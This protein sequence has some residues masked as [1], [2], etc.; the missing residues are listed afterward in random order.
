VAPFR[1][2]V[3][4]DPY[5]SAA[6]MR[7]ALLVV[8]SDGYDWS[9]PAL[10]DELTYTDLSL[11]RTPTQL[12]VGMTQYSLLAAMRGD[13]TIAAD[14]PDVY[15][16]VCDRVTSYIAAVFGGDAP[17]SDYTGFTVA[18][19]AGST[20]PPTAEQ[21]RQ[22][23][24]ARGAAR[25]AELWQE[26]GLAQSSPPLVAESVL[27][28]MGYGLLRRGAGA[29]AVTV[30]RMCSEAYPHSA[31]AWDSYAEATLA[32]G[33]EPRALELYRRALEVLPH[34]TTT[35]RDIKEVI[36]NNAT[37]VVERLQETG[38]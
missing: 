19:R 17:Q 4:E 37:Q 12:P 34:D 20:P 29:D 36:R 6:R 10:A 23:L 24:R 18:E 30:F 33:D 13:S 22:I 38:Q 26:F 14:V 32:L 7:S 15:G 5:F 8:D 11:L 1:S 3:R 2:L 35:S 28:N 27:N 9:L 25:A 21:F 31:N 16:R